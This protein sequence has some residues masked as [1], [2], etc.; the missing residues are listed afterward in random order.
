MDDDCAANLDHR[1]TLT[2]S[3]APRKFS[4]LHRCFVLQKAGV[5]NPAFTRACAPL[6]YFSSASV[7][8]RIQFADDH[9][10][11]LSDSLEETFLGQ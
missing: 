11:S 1:Q 2:A 6:K 8:R 3:K 9:M 7:L 4:K 10:F 5:I